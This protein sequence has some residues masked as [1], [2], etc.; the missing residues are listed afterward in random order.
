MNYVDKIIPEHKQMGLMERGFIILTHENEF[1]EKK[2][3][4]FCQLMISAIF[5]RHDEELIKN[6]FESDYD[7][8]KQEFSN[9]IEIGTLVF[10][11]KN[12]LI[13]NY[14]NNLA[15]VFY[16]SFSISKNIADILR[17]KGYSNGGSCSHNNEAIGIL[18]NRVHYSIYE[19]ADEEEMEKTFKILNE[20]YKTSESILLN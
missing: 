12:N 20:N 14:L 13:K 10:M 5:K 6:E 18:A 9:T 19:I 2:L 16:I 17:S 1:S 7:I 3:E 8:L 15:V 11:A 4:E